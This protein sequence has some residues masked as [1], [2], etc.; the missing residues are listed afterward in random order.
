MPISA[1]I[2]RQGNPLLEGLRG[3]FNMGQ[4]IKQSSYNDKLAKLKNARAQVDT[5]LSVLKGSNPDDPASWGGAIEKL[6]ELGIDTKAIPLTGGKSWLEKQEMASIPIKERLEMQINAIGKGAILQDGQYVKDP[7]SF[8]DREV[9]SLLNIANLQKAVR[10]GDLKTKK[11]D[12]DVDQ[13]AKKRSDKL[14]KDA[15][16]SKGKL[17][18]IMDEKTGL[19]IGLRKAPK[20]P[21]GPRAHLGKETVATKKVDQAFATDYVKWT[22]GGFSNVQTNLQKLEDVIS[23]LDTRD[24][25]TGPIIGSAGK[26]VRDFVN[27]E[28]SAVEET[29]NSVI[30]QSLKQILGGQ[31]SE[32]E[33]QKLIEASYNVRLDEKKNA[34]KLRYTLNQLKKQ[35]AAKQAAGE[36]YEKWGTLRGYK[37]SRIY[38]IAKGFGKKSVPKSKQDRAA[39]RWARKNRKDPRAKAILKANGLEK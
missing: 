14:M 34:K 16:A 17:E 39:V 3:G 19:A 1:D 25:L 21:P 18:P 12:Y 8:S 36:Y 4:L 5:T 28:S 24:D 32:K 15:A 2:Y 23:S 30:M 13:D 10:E 6:K 7:E 22:Q 33:G 27:P 20:P 9:K 11:F 37:G 26:A 29:V 31:F 35:V 38:K